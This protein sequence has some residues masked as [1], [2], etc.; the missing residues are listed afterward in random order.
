[1]SS[2]PRR[3]TRA[4][5]IVTLTLAIATLVSTSVTNAAPTR[6]TSYL[7]D[8]AAIVNGSAMTD[9]D[10]QARWPFLVAIVS[11]TSESQYDGQFCGGSLVDDQHVVTAA[12]C[13]TIDQGTAD[14]P[15]V[16]NAASS[17]R[18][19]ATTRTLDRASMGTGASAARR[20]TEIFV[21]PDFAENA[22]DGFRN[23][24][25]V[26][27]LA[28]P[29][30][31]A[32]TIQLVQAADA[33]AWGNG[34]GGV[35]AFIAG[36]GD[37][38]P[39]DRGASDSKFP[40]DLR[41]ATIPINAD[42]ACGS[43]VGGGYGTAYERA[44]N[45]CG[46]QLASSS[47]TLGRDA[48]QG[49]SGGPLVVD[50]GGSVR[51]LAGLTSWGEG[52]AQQTFGAYSRIDALRSWIDGVP[53]ATDGAPAI[54]G[55]GGTLGVSNLR[56]TGGDF[57][58]VRIAWDAPTLGTHPERYAIWR[59]VIADGDAAEQLEGITTS[60]SFRASVDP[61]RRVN[62][63]TWNVR[64][65]DAAGSNG[66]SATVKAGPTAD[67]RAPSAP[68]T[69]TLVRRGFNALVVRWGAGRDG[70]SGVASYEVQQ[71]VLGFGSFISTGSTPRGVHSILVEELAP[72]DRAVV[73]VR[74]RDA[75]GNASAWRTSPV[76]TTRR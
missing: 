47:T 26:L 18:V 12:H 27:R 64:P 34:E 20:V 76:L 72:G 52:C 54:A 11:S 65:L 55:P 69:I 17:M 66:P 46:G 62:A 50:V 2:H 71:R 51:R 58:H 8:V 1:M 23:D 33:G 43:T 31:G 67:T 36:W 45:L 15:K 41:E 73:R 63:Y 38:D 22:G 10:F 13:V 70:Q 48:C 40:A 30:G 6:R 24:V 60:T 3:V 56:R 25:A 59:R 61:A 37:T 35:N 4:A 57:R 49:D 5:S 32:A 29:I 19:V 39:L 7:P 28:E 68:A 44:T 42:A 16:V 74:T 14:E 21:H 75:A 53:G 9:A